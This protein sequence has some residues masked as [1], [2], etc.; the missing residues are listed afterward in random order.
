MLSCTPTLRRVTQMGGVEHAAAAAAAAA[1]RVRRFAAA[2]S[3]LGWQT[4]GVWGACPVGK[5]YV[6]S[7]RMSTQKG[8]S[9]RKVPG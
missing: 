9:L 5:L 3:R 7:E 4:G 2:E 1:V 6:E 8:Y